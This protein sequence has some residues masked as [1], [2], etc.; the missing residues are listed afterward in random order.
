MTLPLITLAEAK[1][2]LGIRDSDNSFDT[3]VSSLVMAS[4]S[5]IESALNITLARAELTEYFDVSRSYA[6]MYDMQG[7]SED[8]VVIK[9]REQRFSLK[10]FL[11][12]ESEGAVVHY[13]QNREFG[14]D[15]LMETGDYLVN[16][17]QRLLLVFRGLAEGSQVLRIT[18][19]AGI[20]PTTVSAE[21]SLSVNAPY[22]LKMACTMQTAYMFRRQRSESI[23]LLEDRGILSDKSYSGAARWNVK[24]GLCR[25]AQGYLKKYKRPAMGRG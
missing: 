4:T 13:D 16:W 15:T 19:T 14:D 6:T 10:G 12:D 25:E 11:P 18:Y 3:V 17:T 7:N 23:G 9:G 22:D 20:T 1:S 8:G 21:E 5:E 24:G 2:F